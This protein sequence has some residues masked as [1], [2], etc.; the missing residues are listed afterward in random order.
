LH[1]NQGNPGQGKVQVERL[2]SV[3]ERVT[4]QRQIE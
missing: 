2:R 3:L 4:C 1:F